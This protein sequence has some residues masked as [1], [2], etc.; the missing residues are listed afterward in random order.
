MKEFENIQKRMPYSESEE[1]L[2]KLV[3]KA[4]EKAI[5]QGKTTKPQIRRIYTVMAAAAA[6]LL[7]MTIGVMQFHTHEEQL[8]MVQQ[9]STSLMADNSTTTAEDPGPID[10][11]LNGLS[12]EEVQMLAY[13]EMDDIPEY[14]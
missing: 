1:Y 10:D 6:V 8:A 11:F 12:D 7:L 9:E 2:D 5:R 14:E 4:T 13:Y 3:E